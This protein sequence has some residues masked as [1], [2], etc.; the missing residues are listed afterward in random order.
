M[1]CRPVASQDDHASTTLPPKSSRPHQSARA[2]GQ[3]RFARRRRNQ[4][5]CVR[6]AASP[7]SCGVSRTCS[8]RQR[9]WTM[10]RCR[11]PILIG[12][13]AR[14]RRRRKSG[15]RSAMSRCANLARDAGTTG[16]KQFP[17]PPA[18][19]LER[20]AVGEF[21]ARQLATASP[22]PV[23]MPSIARTESLLVGDRHHRASRR[24][25]PVGDGD[26]CKRIPSS[27]REGTCTRP[28]SQHLTCWTRATGSE[29]G[30]TISLLG[31]TSCCS[32]GFRRLHRLAVGHPADGLASRPSASRASKSR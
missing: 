31:A 32:P 21:I 3:G 11:V 6:P 12:P 15:V 23:H 17:G 1:P 7:G 24:I 9:T 20:R 26:G 18:C 8:R 5:L 10:P 25:E 2:A 29:G 16:L 30:V 27:V 19:P 28:G 13:E 22:R 4:H 14:W